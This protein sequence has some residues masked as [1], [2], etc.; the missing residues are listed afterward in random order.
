MNIKT[1]QN[2]GLTNNHEQILK[3]LEKHHNERFFLMEFHKTLKAH[4]LQ[5]FDLYYIRTI[6]LSRIGVW[7]EM[8][9]I[10]SF[11]SGGC[12]LPCYGLATFES[13]PINCFYNCLFNIDS[14][15]NELD[16]VTSNMTN[17]P[18]ISTW[19]TEDELFRILKSLPIITQ[20]IIG[21]NESNL[22]L[23]KPYR[24]RYKSHLD[25]IRQYVDEKKKKK[26]YC[27]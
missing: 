12:C 5:S 24:L 21:N 2:N 6:K 8:T 9:K 23:T 10:I 17:E 1:P 14:Q 11:C 27:K 7:L 22:L 15:L 16:N 25:A 20:T 26:K 4:R 18:Y 13:L 19:L 3:F